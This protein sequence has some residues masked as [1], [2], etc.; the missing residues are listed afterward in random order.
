M[1]LPSHAL[2]ERFVDELVTGKTAL[3]GKFTRHHARGEVRVVVRFDLHLRLGE[4]GADELSN[5][6]RIHAAGY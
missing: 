6:F 1:N 4:G 3:A 5:L 2:T